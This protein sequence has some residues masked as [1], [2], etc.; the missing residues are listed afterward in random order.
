MM[1]IEKLAREAGIHN[2]SAGSF[3]GES[4]MIAP[5]GS[6]KRF[7]ALVA[8]E[9]AKVCEEMRA[10]ESVAA[11]HYAGNFQ[12]AFDYHLQ[13]HAIIADVRDAIRERFKAS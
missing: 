2:V 11:A 9:A 13:R 1:D 3:F 12:Q 7:A 5:M 8:E 10:N 6:W 4:T